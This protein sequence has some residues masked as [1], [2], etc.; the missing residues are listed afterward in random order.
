[1]LT[2][3]KEGAGFGDE[4]GESGRVLLTVGKEDGL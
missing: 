2:P 1:M 3:K 4:S